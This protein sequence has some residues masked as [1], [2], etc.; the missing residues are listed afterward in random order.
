MSCG[1]LTVTLHTAPLTAGIGAELRLRYF[2]FPQALATE[3]RIRTEESR[4]ADSDP[5]RRR[6]VSCQSLMAC[7]RALVIRSY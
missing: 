6:C 7:A 5:S 1:Q 4:S 3:M 2:S